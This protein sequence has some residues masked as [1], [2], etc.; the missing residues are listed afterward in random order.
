MLVAHVDTSLHGRSTS[1]ESTAATAAKARSATLKN[2][3]ETWLSVY[4]RYLP[5]LAAARTLN[6]LAVHRLSIEGRICMAL[7]IIPAY[8]DCQ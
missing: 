3:I 2:K 6:A 5:A 7:D 4:K 8:T 1:T